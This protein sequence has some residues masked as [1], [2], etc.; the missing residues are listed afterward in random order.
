MVLKKHS[1]EK[2]IAIHEVVSYEEQIADLKDATFSILAAHLQQ[3]SDAPAYP[4]YLCL[5]LEHLAM[6]WYITHPGLNIY[7]DVY[8]IAQVNSCT[9]A[10]T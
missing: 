5:L 6:L 4:F 7:A 9:A 10:P 1:K 8:L 2:E 3:N